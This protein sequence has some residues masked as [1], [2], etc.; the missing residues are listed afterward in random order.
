[1]RASQFHPLVAT[2]LGKAKRGPVC[3]LPAGWEAEPVAVADVARHLVDRAVEGPSGAVSEFAGPERLGLRAMARLWLAAR[4]ERAVVLPVPVP[5]RTA[6]AFRM[7]SNIASPDAARGQV[8][9]ADWLS[10]NAR[11]SSR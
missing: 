4:G 7:R 11:F 8:T 1:M 6:R 3:V 10:Q 9:W 5:G 2:L